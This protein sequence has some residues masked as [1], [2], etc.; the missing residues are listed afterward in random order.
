MPMRGAEPDAFWQE[1]CQETELEGRSTTQEVC[2]EGHVDKIRKN[3]FS[4]PRSHSR[5]GCR[6]DPRWSTSTQSGHKRKETS[7]K[8]HQA[9]AYVFSDSARRGSHQKNWRQ[10]DRQ[11]PTRREHLMRAKFLDCEFNVLVSPPHSRLPRSSF[12]SQRDRP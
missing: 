6:C 1:V 10:V 4:L 5:Q 3:S 2:V 8:V 11:S 12:D 9:K 7:L